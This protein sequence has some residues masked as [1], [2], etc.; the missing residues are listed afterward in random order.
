MQPLYEAAVKDLPAVTARAIVEDFTLVGPP[1]Q[2]FEAFDRIMASAAG[3]GVHVNATKTKVQQP[4]G[5]PTAFTLEAA[6]ARSLEVLRGNC[7]LLG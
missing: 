5:A 2:T 6:A 3:V 1:R 4:C 7:K